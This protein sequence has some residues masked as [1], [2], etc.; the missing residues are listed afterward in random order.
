MTLGKN[1]IKYLSSLKIKKYRDTEK[2]FVIE[3]DKIVRDA[4]KE[5]PFILISW[6]QP[7]RGLKPTNPLPNLLQRLLKRISWISGKYLPLK[8]RPLLLLYSIFRESQWIL[9]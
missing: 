8:R 9:K 7:S 4:L 2:Q 1:R 6:W 5:E 3:G